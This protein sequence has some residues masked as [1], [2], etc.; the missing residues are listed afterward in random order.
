MEMAVSHQTADNGRK[1]VL[2]GADHVQLPVPN[3]DDAVEWYT[4]YLG[5]Q[6]LF[7]CDD[8]ATL[9]SQVM[10][11]LPTQQRWRSR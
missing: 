2:E 5:F 1:P 7:K 8:L 3:I 4:R 10:C 6:L 9:T 11:P